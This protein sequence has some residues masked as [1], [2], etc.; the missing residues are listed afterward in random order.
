MKKVGV[1]ALDLPLS[2][3][4]IFIIIA[5]I[6][7]SKH[8]FLSVYC[9]VSRHYEL[10]QAYPFAVTVSPDFLI[11]GAMIYSHMFYNK[12]YRHYFLSRVV[13]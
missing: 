8:S 5:I 7:T 9:A 12:H 2:L 4:Y 6:L 1:N 10:E 13:S 3:F 11:P